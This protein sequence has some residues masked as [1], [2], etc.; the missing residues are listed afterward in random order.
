L[1]PRIQE[2]FRNFDD[3]NGYVSREI[4][5]EAEWFPGYA[6]IDGSKQFDAFNER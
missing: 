5:N 2:N 1:I 4:L 6:R 3:Y